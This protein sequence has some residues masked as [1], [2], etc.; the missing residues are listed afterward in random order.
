MRL[1][2]RAAAVA[3][4]TLLVACGPVADVDGAGDDA[5]EEGAL[6]EASILAYL[7]GPDSSHWSLMQEVHLTSRPAG[8]IH[9][10]LAGP[11]GVRF[12]AD[13]DKIE[14]IAELD[15]IPF[16]GEASIRALEAYVRSHYQ[17][18]G[19]VLEGVT[20]S[21]D[22]AVAMVALANT[23][24][25][26]LLDDDVA[27]DARAARAIV[28]ARP[29]ATVQVLAAVSYVNGTA[30]TKLRDWVIT[31]PTAVPANGP[32]IVALAAATG[33]WVDLEWDESNDG[34]FVTY[35][36]ER[37]TH[38]RLE[39]LSTQGAVLSARGDG[40]TDG[41]NLGTSE[42]AYFFSGSYPGEP[43]GVAAQVRLSCRDDAGASDVRT[44]VP[45]EGPRIIDMNGR[46]GD[47]VDGGQTRGGAF[48]QYATEH[49]G[50]CTIELSSPAESAVLATRAAPASGTVFVPAWPA[51]EAHD[52]RV[53]LECTDAVVGALAEDTFEVT[54]TPAPPTVNCAAMTGGSFD[55]V[56]FSA[57]EE[58][59]AVRFLDFA[60]FSEMGRMSDSGRRIAYDCAPGGACGFRTSSWLRLAQFADYAGVGTVALEGLKAS[61]A[62]WTQDGL[63][64]D[65]V[66]HTWQNRAALVDQPVSF[67]NVYVT[68]RLDNQVSATGNVYECI[69][70]KD[71]P[72]STNYLSACI[73]RVSS[74]SAPG[75]SMIPS[76]CLDPVVG[77]SVSLR[78]AL[79]AVAQAPGG[80]RVT[81]SSARPGAPNPAAAP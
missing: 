63:T 10:Y 74:D 19:F 73:G 33:T 49:A 8:A 13:D 75:C 2:L 70:L 12:N 81:L 36:S 78:G 14:S 56:S 44:V 45:V 27:L 42:S 38:C 71:T 72:T 77:T 16:V 6:D 1:A 3:A 9:T 54:A 47:G 17:G 61:I 67:D 15:A 23:A 68:R 46:V 22:N 29:I 76:Q 65:T 50:A 69:E 4:I 28:A 57:D 60:R 48:V 37:A 58:C 20:I 21:A 24:T 52:V 59:Q 64:W 66:A 43:H 30:L 41:A 40:A 39:L 51:G 31:H 11:D 34:V 32:R 79:R 80:Y 25:V 7:N 5:A 62:G 18:A 53:R 26:E 55:G 35:E